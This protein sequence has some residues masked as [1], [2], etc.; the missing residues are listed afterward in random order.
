MTNETLIQNLNVLL[1]LKSH[2]KPKTKAQFAHWLAG[3]I[4]ADGH[5]SK[6]GYVQIEFHKKDLR[7]IYYIKQ[8]I[9][10]GGVY[11]YKTVN[12]CRY[13]CSNKTGQVLICNLTKLR[14]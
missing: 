7:L 10:F 6:L 8:L 11:K 1:N 12:A 13:T 5:I 9:G 14:N 2:T 4:D 3:L